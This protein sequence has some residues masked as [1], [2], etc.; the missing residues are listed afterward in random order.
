MNGLNPGRKYPKT[1][2]T[3]PKEKLAHDWKPV[4]VTTQQDK[5]CP[6]LQRRFRMADILLADNTPESRKRYKA[7]STHSYGR[8]K[9]NLAGVWNGKG[10]TERKRKVNKFCRSK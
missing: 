10:K 5:P 6:K 4:K 3:M 1:Q 8:T 7:M 9:I 2:G